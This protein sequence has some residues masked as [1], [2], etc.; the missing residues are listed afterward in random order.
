MFLYAPLRFRLFMLVASWLQPNPA[1]KRAWPNSYVFTANGDFNSFGSGH[2][3][4]RPAPY[5]RR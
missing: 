4:G 5:F 3:S 2:R 1:V